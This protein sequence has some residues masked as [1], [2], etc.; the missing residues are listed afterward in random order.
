MIDVATCVSE[1]KWFSSQTLWRPTDNCFINL[2]FVERFYFF[3]VYLLSFF[4]FFNQIEV[5]WNTGMSISVSWEPYILFGKKDQETTCY[6]LP[7]EF[8]QSIMIRNNLLVTENSMWEYIIL[9]RDAICAVL[10]NWVGVQQM[11]KWGRI[12]EAKETEC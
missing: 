9:Q 6:K 7:G 5:P 10:K 12:S 2:A 4:F 3:F 8:K 1:S 11:E